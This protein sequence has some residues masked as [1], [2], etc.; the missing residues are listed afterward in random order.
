VS[1]E[2][3]SRPLPG[4]G[5][6]ECQGPLVSETQLRVASASHA[7]ERGLIPGAGT[8]LNLHSGNANGYT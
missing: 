1:H 8:F 4:A 5:L 7:D 3:Q 6:L 2:L